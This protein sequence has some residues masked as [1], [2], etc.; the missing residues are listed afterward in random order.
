[1]LWHE[2]IAGRTAEE[3]ASVFIAYIRKFEDISELTAWLDNCGAQGKNWWLLTAIAYEVNRRNGNMD[4]IT[5]KYF[6]PGHTFMSA[7]SFHHLVE[8]GIRKARRVQ[9]FADFVNI[10]NE[11]GQAH[12]M[13]PTEFKAITRGLSQGQKVSK[14]RPY[15]DN[16]R[17]IQ[18]R[19][20]SYKIFWKESHTEDDFRSSEFLMDK[21]KNSMKAGNDFPSKKQT[22]GAN[23]EKI[24]NIIEKLCPH[25]D[26]V[27]RTFWE[28]IPLNDNSPDLMKERDPNEKDDQED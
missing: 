18:F 23:T 24:N 15:L 28:Q 10:V 11:K 1:M 25:M 27:K 6:E 19:H 22:R 20:G 21:V 2:G 7:D 3:V 5:L 4:I 17:V 16:C 13:I 12:E 26:A 14:T 9:N 8:Q